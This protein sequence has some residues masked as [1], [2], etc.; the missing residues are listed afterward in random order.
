MLKSKLVISRLVA[1]G[2]GHPI[3]KFTVS[4]VDNELI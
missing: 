3:E 4:V 2:V 1:D